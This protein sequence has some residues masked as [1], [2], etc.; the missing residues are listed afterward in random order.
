MVHEK[1]WRVSLGSGTL[2]STKFSLNSCSHS[3][4]SEWHRSPRSWSWSTFLFGFGFFD[5]FSQQLLLRYFRRAQVSPFLPFNMFTWHS[6]GIGIYPTQVTPF[7]S[8]H[9]F[10][11]HRWRCHG[12][13]GTRAWGRRRMINF[14]P[15]RCY[16]CWRGKNW[17]KILLTSLE[18][19]SERSSLCCTVSAYRFLWDV[20]F[21]CWSIHKNIR[22][23]RIAFRATILLACFSR[24]FKV[25]NISNS[26]TYNVGSSFVCTSPLAVMTI[27]GLH[28]FVKVSISASL[29]SF[30][31]DHMH[32]RTGVGVRCAFSRCFNFIF[33]VKHVE[34]QDFNLFD[35][36]EFIQ[37]LSC[38]F[39]SLRSFVVS[40][41]FLIFSV[42][43]FLC[44]SCL[45]L[46]IFQLVL[47]NQCLY[48]PLLSRS[49][50]QL[51]LSFIFWCYWFHFLCYNTQRIVLGT[52][53]LLW[54]V[55]ASVS[56]FNIASISSGFDASSA[57]SLCFCV[58]AA[59]SYFVF[60]AVVFWHMILKFWNV[61]ATLMRFTWTNHSERRIWVSNFCV[62]CD[63]FCEL[64][65]LDWFLH[66]GALP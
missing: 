55:A 15:W 33:V 52:M 35:S 18:P 38:L 13:W 62:T 60:V 59:A 54:S 37:D 12:W 50:P 61:G 47:G 9:T 31:A 25:K 23:H 1:N 2:S 57:S 5:W 11:W 17:R 46:Y 63:G 41:V 45:R 34:N 6:C 27:V 3:G 14:L 26:L 36:F 8:S 42:N 66:V 22:F 65:T 16:G 39:V 43:A 19:R 49:M 24:T 64:N 51:C 7:V 58:V 53:L 21:D 4:L 56:S 29:K 44:L 28:D 40:G 10:S 30:F 32:W 20:V 48:L